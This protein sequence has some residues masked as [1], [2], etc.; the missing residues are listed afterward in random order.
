MSVKKNP[1]VSV[2]IPC[3]AVGDYLRKETIPALTRQSYKNFEVMILPDRPAKEKF[4]KTK[5]ISTWPKLG[6]AD[7]KDIG[8]KSARGS[9]IAFI[10]DDA[11]PDE[12]WLKNA[13]KYFRNEK[14]AA[15]CGPGITPWSGNISMLAGK[16]ER[17]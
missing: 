6:P 16:K 2:I 14:I 12:N 5:I 3:K 15:V 10:D 1:L 7:K 8:V 11:Y 4:P 9:L 17:S 13:V